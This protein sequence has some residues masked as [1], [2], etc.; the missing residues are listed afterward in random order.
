MLHEIDIAT[1]RSRKEVNW[2]NKA[3]TW[4]ALVEKLSQTHRTAE[5]LAEYNTAKKTRQDEIKD[6]GGFVGGYM[7]GRR[8]VSTS[9]VHRQLVTLDVDFAKPG[10]WDD[11]ALM[12]GN[13]ACV[14]STHKHTPEAPRL[15]LVI[16]LDREVMRD[17]YEPICRRIAG[18]L[19]VDLFDPTTYQPERL[20]Y[21]PST[22][23]DGVFEFHQQDGPWL[24]ADEVLGRYVDWRNSSEWPVS[25]AEGEVVARSIKKQGDPLEK[26]GIVG[27]FCRTYSIA[28]AI[29]KYLEDV[30]EPCDIE[31]RYSY[32]EGSTAA[33]LVV[34][35]DKF[36][37][38]HHGT[39][40]VSGKLCNAFDLVRLHKFGLKD[41]DKTNDKASTD[42]MY[43]F[44]AADPAVRTLMTKEGLEAAKEDFANVD[45]EEEQ[46][47]ADDSWMGNIKRDKNGIKNTIDNAVIIMRNDP[48]LK[49]RIGFNLFSQREV[50]LKDLPWRRVRDGGKEFKDADESS[51]RHYLETLY[52]LSGKEKINDALTIVLQDNSFH[53][54]KDYFKSLPAWDGV[55][56]VDTLFID[57]LGAEDCIY[58]REVTRKSLV[59]AVARIFDPGVKFDNMPVTVGPQGT[60]KS[61]ILDRLGGQWFTD[62]FNF[63]MLKGD[64]KRGEEQIQGA[65]IVEIG[66]LAG[67]G[68]AD[69]ESAK[70]FLSRR[71]DKYRAAYGKRIGFNPRQCVFFGTTNNDEFLRDVTGNRRFWPLPTDPGM[72][73]K[74][75]FTDLHRGEVDQIWSEAFVLY[76]RGEPLFLSKEIDALAIQM[77]DM[78]TETDERVGMIL[79]YLDTPLP[80]N[81]ATLGVWERRNWLNSEDIQPAGTTQR[82]VTCA[83]EIWIE[84]FG[85]SVKD[86]T[87]QNTK[88]IN[89]VLRKAKGWEASKSNRKFDFCGVQRAFVR[90]NKTP[91]KMNEI[92]K[93]KNP[94]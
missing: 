3:I 10:F 30:Y 67:L 38:S 8:R 49:N 69:M 27:A 21:W 20:M 94:D 1:G 29:E 73:V 60:G 43:R 83:A 32:K 46:A 44:A 74:S 35:D 58:T 81:W 19:G 84:L 92:N 64:S 7:S 50:L 62:S 45:L 90:M 82:Q 77:Q 2:R 6:I 68:R 91:K 89:E 53:P 57:Y 41:E 37:Y 65:W 47:P 51:L 61:T 87:R 28:E 78:H 13:A 36:A 11:F 34:Y 66:E 79:D 80:E 40:P 15:R 86:A 14:Y 5:T 4:P 56:R 54:V 55:P 85:G 33:G 93:E 31:N 9:I 88:F 25:E 48:Q 23:K 26:P 22:S 71:E 52:D 59:A 75:V 70:S 24:S 39:D 76:R 17:E 12:Y 72:A 42:E 63:H 18:D 16:P